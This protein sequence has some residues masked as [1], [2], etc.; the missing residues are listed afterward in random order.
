MEDQYLAQS[1]IEM[2]KLGSSPTVSTASVL[3]VVCPMLVQHINIVAC[4][5]MAA[6]LIGVIHA[7]YINSSTCI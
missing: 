3:R 2:I 5:I 4:I 6:G 7:T 1:I